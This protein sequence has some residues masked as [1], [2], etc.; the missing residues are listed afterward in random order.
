MSESRPA[1]ISVFQGTALTLG[2]L[3]GTGVIS[4]PGL[5]AGRAGAASLVAWG[6][7]L[8]ISIPLATTFTALGARHPGGGG[9]ATYT[10][11][12]FGERAAVAL[13][14]A[15]FLAIPIGAPVAAGFA[16]AYVADALGQGRQTTFAATAA[17]I[18]LVTVLNWFGIRLSARVQLGV[19]AILAVVLAV[20]V[21]V[22]LP[23]ASAH[24]LTPFAPH[25][26]R[27]IMSSAGVL[28]WAFAGWEIMASMSGEYADPKRDIGRAAAASLAIVGVLYLG[29]AFATVAVLGSSPGAAPL[30]S[31]LV[32][33]FGSAARPAMTIVALLLTVGT[34]NSYFAGTARLGQSLASDGALPAWLGRSGEPRRPLLLTSGLALTT[35]LLLD[36]AGRGT[37]STLLVTTGTFALAYLTAT[38][39]AVRLLPRG[40]WGRRAAIVSVVA[41]VA[42]V[43][44]TGI[45][46]L[47][48]LA[49]GLAGLVWFSWRRRTAV[50]V[51]RP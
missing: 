18:V 40:S 28:V 31:L 12:A 7:L 10:R 37:D 50:A 1:G 41:S 22:A 13:G 8:L 17:I 6:A 30:S 19:A 14:W 5:A 23:H 33:G 36:L 46:V 47:L 2:S 27:G 34:M 49:I 51:A 15:F 25:G 26:F 48:P 39:A 3:L 4:L 29:I 32:L 43:A 9:V 45:A 38:A 44:S 21:V 35:A 24:N 42:L 16:G 20:T 11:L